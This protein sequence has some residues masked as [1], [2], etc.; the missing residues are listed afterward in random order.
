MKIY[1]R[2]VALTL[3]FAS[4]QSSSNNKKDSNQKT[5]IGAT[6]TLIA[7]KDTI[8]HSENFE[9][10]W[11]SFRQSVVNSDTNQIIALTQFPFET[12]GPLDSDPTIKHTKQKFAHVFQAFLNQWNGM[13][14]DGTTERESI[15]KTV[16]IKKE[17]IADEYTRVGNLVFSKK[18]SGWRLVFAYLNNETIDTLSK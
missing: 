14:L 10:F 18:K 7:T 16:T 15:E 12:R 9:E 11:K 1:L 17:D 8:R 5:D 6:P 3:L 13:D 4:C 2:L